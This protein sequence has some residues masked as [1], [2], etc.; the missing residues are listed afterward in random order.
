MM[1]VRNCFI[2]VEALTV[3]RF[4]TVDVRLPLSLVGELHEKKWYDGISVVNV[5]SL[6]YQV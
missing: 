1:Y 5:D 4:I 3:M 6:P 2:T